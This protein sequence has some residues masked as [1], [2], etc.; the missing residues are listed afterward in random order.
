MLN[1]Y[2]DERVYMC[3]LS[4]TISMS[5]LYLPSYCDAQVLLILGYKQELVILEVQFEDNANIVWSIS[6]KRFSHLTARSSEIDVVQ[7]DLTV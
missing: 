5:H 3:R 6:I 1:C 7:F 2:L 4:Y